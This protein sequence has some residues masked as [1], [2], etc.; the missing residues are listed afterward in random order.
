MIYEVLLR[1]MNNLINN[2]EV[3]IYRT[4]IYNQSNEDKKWDILMLK[5]PISPL[6]LQ[7]PDDRI[8]RNCQHCDWTS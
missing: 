6:F 4:I 1:T 2:H 3:T 5:I 8:R 7:A